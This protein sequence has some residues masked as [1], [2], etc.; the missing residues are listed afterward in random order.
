MARK[1]KASNNLE[2]TIDSSFSLKKITPLTETQHDLFDA[3]DEGLNLVVCGS[4][5]TGKSFV[6]IYLALRDMIRNPRS[7]QVPQ[8]IMIIRSAV[9]SRDLGFLP[10]TAKEKMQVYEPPYVEIFAKLFGRGDAWEILKTKNIV[11]L[12]ATSFLRG[13]TIDNT[14]IILDEFQNCNFQEIDTVMTRVGENSRV[15]L[16]GDIGQNDLNKNKYDQSGFPELIRIVDKMS[17]MEIIEF[18]HEDICR[19]NF[20]KEYIIA[21][22]TE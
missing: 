6:S 22:E 19:S 11:S 1:Q 3:F 5:G 18:G 12:V 15:M 4:A 8:K 7:T 14:F 16:I 17:S 10:G 21:K 9:P 20:V 13:T 2:P